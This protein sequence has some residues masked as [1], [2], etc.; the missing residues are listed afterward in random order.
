MVRMG[1]SHPI[2]PR[3]FM[4]RAVESKKV[5][6]MN[7]KSGRLSAMHRAIAI[8]GFIVGSIAATAFAQIVPSAKLPETTPWDLKALSATPR[9]EWV[10]KV[11]PVR[12]VFYAGEPYGGKPTRVFAY[13]ATP[14]TLAKQDAKGEK[15]PAVVLVHG[16]GG[17]AFRE[18]CELWGKRGYAAIAMD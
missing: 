10:D 5:C 9:F 15:Y 12:S 11:A 18:W 8:L 13:Y 3:C 2:L 16:G 7:M 14:A 4:N 6:S 1:S 17:T